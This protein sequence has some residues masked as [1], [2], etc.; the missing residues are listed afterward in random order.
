M[1]KKLTASLF[2]LSAIAV[3]G[4]SQDAFAV[5]VAEKGKI[6]ADATEYKYVASDTATITFTVETENKNSQK[7]VEINNQK[8]TLVIA[9]I[10]KS[11]AADEAIKTSN[12]NLRQKYEYNS[13]TKKNNTV[14]Y[15]VTNSITVKLKDTQKTGKI[16]DL[17][18][19]SG[20]TSVGGLSF[21]LQNTD[22]VCKELTQ[23]A[24]LKAKAQAQDV[25]A[26]L[27]KTIDSISSINYS[28]STN[29]PSLYRNFAMAKGAF[30]EGAADTAVTI[31]QGETRV[32]A[33][34]TI[35]FTIK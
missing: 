32:N 3:L 20:V 12:Y 4:F 16:I 17:A 6:T 11:L 31:E 29:T 24:I 26:P 22:A 5:V 15:V 33:S 18:T 28:C 10:K 21:T 9:A 14:G 1:M 30:A 19:K 2:A 27:G 13:V 25:L 7:A 8:T 35:V 23:K 34:V